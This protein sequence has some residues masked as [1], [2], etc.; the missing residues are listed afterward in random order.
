MFKYISVYLNNMI[1]N[2]DL[3]W[4]VADGLDWNLLYNYSFKRDIC[5]TLL[6]QEIGA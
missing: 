6:Y 3:N 1:I 5:D 2:C 4:H